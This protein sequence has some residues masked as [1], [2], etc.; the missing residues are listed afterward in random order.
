[1][2]VHSFFQETVVSTPR[3]QPPGHALHASTKDGNLQVSRRLGR[4]QHPDPPQARREMLAASGLSPGPL[5]R[6]VPRRG[7]TTS[8]ARQGN[9]RRLLR[10]PGGR[11]D[12]RGS[13]PHLPDH[14]QH[15]RRRPRRDRRQPD[16]M[17]HV[18]SRLD[19]RRKPS[20]RP[21]QQISLPLW[22]RR[23]APDREDH[24]V[25]YRIRHGTTLFLNPN[26]NPN[27]FER[28]LLTSALTV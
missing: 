26:P 9:P 3:R 14:A 25:P 4:R 5:F 12:H 1:M 21:P 8:R 7:Q 16:L 18:D 22:P 20:R 19:R 6:R 27:P 2:H 23:H 28:Y 13:T 10:L 11:H 15:S 17:G 24:P